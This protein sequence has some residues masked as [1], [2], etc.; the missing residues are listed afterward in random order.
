MVRKNKI[1]VLILGGTGFIGYHLSKKFIKN[2]WEVT[3]VSKK[4]PPKKDKY[5]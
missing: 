5:I 2:G 1:N 4:L 3:S